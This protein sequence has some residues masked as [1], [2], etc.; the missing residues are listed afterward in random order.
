MLAYVLAVVVLLVAAL[1]AFGLAALIHL[2]GG[3]YLVFVI[4]VLLLGIAAA[5]TIIVL[6]RRAKKEKEQQG[7][8][9]GT[10][11]TAELDLMLN[12]ANR[13]LRTAQQG[14]KALDSL[15]LLYILGDPGSAKTTTV[16]RSGLDPELLAGTATLDGDQ[17]ST[18]VL[19]LWFTK[20]SALLEVGA[21]VRGNSALLGRLVHRTRA[22]AY[23]SAFGSGAAPRAVVVCVSADQLLVADAGQSLMASARGTGAQ[24][25]EISRILGMAVPVYVIVT[26]LDRMPHFA[27]YVRNLSDAEVRQVL[28]SPLS[29]SEASAG[30][31]A[32][33]ASRMLAGIIDGLV[34]QLGEFRV[35]MLDRENDPGSVS[36][37]YEFPRELGKL[38]K[39]L[40]QYLVEL[41]KPSHLSAN[42]YL[43]GFYFTGIRARIVER[44]V[45]APVAVEQRPAAQDAGATQY[46]N[47]S[48]GRTTAR[49]AAAAPVMTQSRVPQWTFACCPR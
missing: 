42:P 47:L 38:R 29:R 28:G 39:N 24:L 41:C 9:P 31:Y 21:A 46:I 8:G 4:I 14:A 36:G 12:D 43:R 23:R 22:K 2:Q 34:Y 13:K 32:E 16:L 40:N 17:V 7:E 45:S 5:I 33:Q 44:A 3:A 11:A 37:V 25:R 19:N 48:M 27:E 1:L 10:G 6:H 35:E 49:A 15:P 30:V 20:A 26:R 18:S